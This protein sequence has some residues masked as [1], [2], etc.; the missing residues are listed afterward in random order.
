[1]PVDAAA[2][3]APDDATLSA[4]F[5]TVKSR[6]EA[7]ALRSARVGYI[8]P[9]LFADDITIDENTLVAA[10]EDRRDEFTTPEQRNLR[11]MVFDN[12]E[13]A[14][15]A[16]TRVDDGEDFNDVAA[17]MLGWSVA[18]VALGL[19]EKADLDDAVAT[20]AFGIASGEFIGPVESAFGFHVLAVDEIVPG[21]DASLDD[22]R[23]EIT[24]ALKLEAATDSIYDSANTLEDALASGSTLDEAIRAVGGQIVTLT[25]ILSL[26][27]I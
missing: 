14:T 23:A 4:W 22:V 9:A 8:S 6:Y 27:H 2:V 20:A 26:I 1:M 17:D 11:Q 13:D 24:A 21:E 5:D 18:D 15:T 7:P 12:V 16:F 19:L 10:F 3:P 25:N